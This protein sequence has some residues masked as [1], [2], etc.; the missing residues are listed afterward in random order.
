M[1]AA[2]RRLRTRRDLAQQEALR[3]LRTMVDELAA[4]LPPDVLNRVGTLL[5]RK[6]A[7]SGKWV[8]TMVNAPLYA[9]YV[10]YLREHSRRPLLSL[11]LLAEL[12]AALPD[13]SNEVDASR[14]DLAARVGCAPNTISELISEMELAGI[15]AR[16]RSGRGVRY[17]INAL[18]GTHLTGAERDRAQQKAAELRVVE[19]AE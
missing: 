15:V 3:R 8:F 7:S 4:S 17:V 14:E 9:E 6:I 11:Q 16:E 18:L 1:P 5:D 12:I 2:V 19:P 10:R 13:D